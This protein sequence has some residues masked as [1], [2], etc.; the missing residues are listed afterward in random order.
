MRS[1]GLIRASARVT[2]HLYRHAYPLY[3]LAYGAYKRVI[4][5]HNLRIIQRL[6]R[7]GDCVAD[8]GANV[9]YYTAALAR[10]VGPGGQ[11]WA[12]EPSPENYDRLAR[13]ARRYPSVHP[14]PAAAVVRGGT[15]TLYL[16][17][18]LNV[19]HR[20]YATDDARHSVT[21]PAV[22]L[23]DV[24]PS[25][26]PL[27]F[28]KIDVQGGELEALQGMAMTAARSP[29]LTI[30]LEVWPFVHDRFGAGTPALLH[31]LATWGLD[32][33]RI[34]GDHFGATVHAAELQGSAP[35]RYFDVLCMRPDRWAEWSA[36]QP[37]APGGG[38]G[39]R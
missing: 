14:V 5:R 19:D 15:T 10:A 39:Q 38:S 35:D 24:L 31:L 13:V 12:F 3:A 33:R 28:L 9:G 18:D 4:E 25:D 22:A 1:D 36:R 20:T 8:V 30:L 7:P 32:P 37:R 23:D 21:V 11:V 34:E 6:V 2:D 26:T 17:P 16:S 29:G 27:S